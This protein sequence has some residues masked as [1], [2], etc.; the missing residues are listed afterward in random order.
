MQFIPLS[1]FKKMLRQSALNTNNIL[2]FTDTS[3]TSRNL[4]APA[5]YSSTAMWTYTNLMPFYAAQTT[6]SSPTVKNMIAVASSDSS[7]SENA[8]APSAIT[9]SSSCTVVARAD[10]SGWTMTITVTGNPGDTINSFYFERKLW[11]DANES[12]YTYNAVIFAVKL[13]NPVTIDSTGSASFTFAIE[14]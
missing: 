3:G 6:A 11:A 5:A 14:F 10:K 4:Y 12:S 1:N 13:D 7:I 8:Y 2:T 9:G